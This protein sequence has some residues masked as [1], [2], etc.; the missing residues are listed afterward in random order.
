M[1][2]TA[3]VCSKRSVEKKNPCALIVGASSGIGREVALLLLE[4]G[5]RVGVCCRRLERLHEL[6]TAT[7][8]RWK[9]RLW[10]SVGLRPLRFWND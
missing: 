4:K 10:M 7:Q 5:W 6:A 8:V 3:T 2:N 1:K 9:L